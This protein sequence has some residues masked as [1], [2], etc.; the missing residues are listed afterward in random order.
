[1]TMNNFELEPGDIL[2]NVN[3]RKDPISTIKRWAAGPFEHVFIYMG[4]VGILIS[5]GQRRIVR[6]SMLFES[7]GDGA[8]IES[9]SSR[10]G[11]EVVILRLKSESDRKRIPHVLEEAIQLAEDP[12][13]HYD[14]LCIVK[15]VLPR[16]ILE[17]L[18]LP[19]WVL[20]HLPLAWQ[21]DRRQICS[22]AVFEIFYRAKLVDILP[23]YCAPPLPGDFIT[24]SMLLDNVWEGILSEELV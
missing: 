22:E 6:V 17:K 5:P 15:H 2:V 11:R 8:I 10:Y 14:Y 3:H 12:Q 1:M 21:R 18:G 24:D 9:L 23:P 4:E 19:T 16:L 7:D 20:S 13:S